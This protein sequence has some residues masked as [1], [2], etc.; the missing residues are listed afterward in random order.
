[1][2]FFLTLLRDMEDLKQQL[3]I[4]QQQV[5]L[6]VSRERQVETVS[7]TEAPLVSAWMCSP[8]SNPGISISSASPVR[9]QIADQSPT[10]SRNLQRDVSV[11]PTPSQVTGTRALSVTDMTDGPFIDQS[12]VV[13]S[14]KSTSGRMAVAYHPLLSFSQ[15]EAM[16]LVDVYEDECGSVYPLINIEHL[17]QFVIQFYDSVTA[18][19]KPATWRTF[20][21]DQSSTRHFNTLEIVLAIAL[22]IEG[23]GSTD[24]SSALMDE[25]EAEIDHRPSGVSADNHLAEILTLMVWCLI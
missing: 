24:L 19:R 4:L 16:R 15:A 2:F 5:S 18:S 6:L 25:L 1:M 10:S 13:T 14:S 8:Q 17:R 12:K 22:V 11:N 9:Q 3:E 23:R 21:L 20:K 7:R